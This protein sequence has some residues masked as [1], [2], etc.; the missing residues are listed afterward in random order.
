MSWSFF[1]AENLILSH[2]PN[3]EFIIQNFNPNGENTYHDIYNSLSTMACLSIGY[4]YIFH[5]RQ[6]G[7]ILS[8]A[9]RFLY[10]RIFAGFLCQSIGLLLVSQLVPKIQLPFVIANQTNNENTVSKEI[11][12]NQPSSTKNQVRVR[13]PMDFKAD[14]KVSDDGFY[15]LERITRHPTFWSLGLV[16]FGNAIVTK[17]ATEAVMFSFPIILASIG[18]AHQD[19]KHMRISNGNGEP[20]LTQAKYEKTSHIPFAALITGKQS[21]KSL[22]EEFKYS[23]AAAAVLIAAVVG[24]KRM[25]VL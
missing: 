16:C 21:W 13:C 23:N 6:T 3:R 11:K 18:G 7:P 14:N 2:P 10:P 1:I 8:F 15:G 5:G 20:V 9:N 12:E 4:T 19:C 17:Y 22:H 25:K 24:I